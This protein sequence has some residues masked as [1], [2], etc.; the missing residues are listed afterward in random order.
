MVGALFHIPFNELVA[1]I[2]QEEIFKMVIG[3]YPDLNK[4]Y[5]SPIRFDN[6]P[7]CYFE[8]YNGVLYF[9]DWAGKRVNSNPVQLVQDYFRLGNFYDAVDFIYKNISSTN[10][11]RVDPIKYS[12]KQ[13]K[14][15]IIPIY[16]NWDLRDKLYWQ[17]FKIKKKELI[18]DLVFPVKNAIVIKS[19]IT[20]KIFFRDVA[21]CITVDKDCYKIYRPFQDKNFK[22][23]SNTNKNLIGSIQKLTNKS[24]LLIITK[25]YKDCRVIRNL[26]YESVWFMSENSIPDT[27]LLSYLTRIYQKIIIFFDNDSAGREF[28]NRLYYIFKEMSSSILI[29]RI[30]SNIIGKKDISEMIHYKGEDYVIDFLNNA[31]QYT[32]NNT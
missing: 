29:K 32:D 2:P 9:V 27:Y 17:R 11:V 14:T 28:S 13:T 15:T 22:W 12:K 8:W 21:Y 6:N 1:E 18:D 31:V 26:G 7:N 30:E 19:N 20:K 25:S 10:I 16:R 3:E 23:L 24:D 4:T 5:R